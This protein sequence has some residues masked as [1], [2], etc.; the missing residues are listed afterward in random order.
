MRMRARHGVLPQERTVGNDYRLD[1][2]VGYPWMEAATTD[3]VNK[4]LN[5]AEL[6][7]LITDVMNVP[8]NLVETVAKNIADA[9]IAKFPM[10]TSVEVKITKIA[11]PMPVDCDGAGVLLRIDNNNIKQ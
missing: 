4:T 9:I 5:Y 11:P 8:C 1:V 6:S 2:N 10:T 7:E 3:D